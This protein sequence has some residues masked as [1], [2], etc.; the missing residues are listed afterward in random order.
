ML[1]IANELIDPL[2]AELVF[3]IV[4]LTVIIL[5]PDYRAFLLY[6]T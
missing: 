1:P 5:S 6:T 4:L 3:T 2:P